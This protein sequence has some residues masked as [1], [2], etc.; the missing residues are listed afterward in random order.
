MNGLPLRPLSVGEVL[1]QSFQ[2]YR[3]HFGR[4][5]LIG[6]L[7]YLPVMI[8]LGTVTGQTVQPVSDPSA[9]FTPAYFVSLIITYMIMGAYWAALAVVCDG[10]VQGTDVTVGHALRKGLVLVPR[11]ILLGIL[12]SLLMVPAMIPAVVLGVIAA[13][14][15]P[16]G[17]SLV[18]GI[19]Y[20]VA[21][22]VGVIIGLVWW[23]PM[24]FMSLPAV[25]GEDAGAAQALSRSN[26]L[27]K[28]G[29]ARITAVG[30]LA[31]FIMMLPFLGA[32]VFLGLGGLTGTAQA[33]VGGV[34]YYIHQIVI[35]GLSALTAPFLVSVMVITYYERRVRREGYDVEM[36][37]AALSAEASQA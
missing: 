13:V 17:H 6:V 10:V 9:I 12:A 29:R 18:L 2:V 20:F 36:A 31:W 15:A 8:L 33:G 23:L 22:G 1:D 25:I 5:L 28:T 30:F 11:L 7:C 3:A 32:G 35:G 14:A 34:Q 19:V 16:A 21:I 27:A 4:L 37:S 26:A 24:Q